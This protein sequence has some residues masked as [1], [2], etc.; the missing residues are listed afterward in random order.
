M[1]VVHDVENPGYGEFEIFEVIIPENATEIPEDAFAIQ[2]IEDLIIPDGVKKI[3]NRA[4]YCCQSLR[5]IVLPLSLESIGKGAF[6]LCDSLKEIIIGP[7]SI[8]GEFGYMNA[9]DDRVDGREY[10]SG[11]EKNLIAAIKYIKTKK[12]LK[13]PTGDFDYHFMP[14]IAAGLWAAESSEEAEDYLG[15]CCEITVEMLLEFNQAY[16]MQALLNSKSLKDSGCIEEAIEY[17]SGTLNSGKYNNEASKVLK[18]YICGNFNYFVPKPEYM[19]V[20]SSYD[21]SFSA[22]E[23]KSVTGEEWNA[24]QKEVCIINKPENGILTPD[25]VLF[26][27]HKNTQ[28]IIY[29]RFII[30]KAV[31]KIT[32]GCFPLASTILLC[33]KDTEIEENGVS[34]K[35]KLIVIGSGK[36]SDYAQKNGNEIVLIPDVKPTPPE[37]IKYYHNDKYVCR[38]S[39]VLNPRTDNK[40]KKETAMEIVLSPE[41]SLNSIKVEFI[42]EGN[43]R[44]P[45][46]MDFRIGNTIAYLMQ[47]DLIKFENAKMLDKQIKADIVTEWPLSDNLSQLFNS[48]IIFNERIVPV[49]K[50]SDMPYDDLFK[51]FFPSV[52]LSV[53]E[54]EVYSIIK[55]MEVPNCSEQILRSLYEPGNKLSTAFSKSKYRLC[56]VKYLEPDKYR[57]VGSPEIDVY[58]KDNTAFYCEDD[59][60]LSEDEA[61]FA[62]T[63]IK[64]YH[65]LYDS[66]FSENMSEDIKKIKRDLSIISPE[67]DKSVLSK[68]FGCTYSDFITEYEAL[69]PS[70]SNTSK[71]NL[72]NFQ[73]NYFAMGIASRGL[74]VYK[75]NK[76]KDFKE[77]EEGHYTAKVEGTKVYDIE[78]YIDKDSM[79]I[80]AS[81][82]CPY[83]EDMKRAWDDSVYRCKHTAAVFY[84]IRNENL[85]NKIFNPKLTFPYNRK[86]KTVSNIQTTIQAKNVSD[87]K[88]SS[89]PKG[90]KVATETV[91]AEPIAKPSDI[92]E[93]SKK[94]SSKSTPPKS[95]VKA[96]SG[97]KPNLL[98]INK[99]MLKKCSKDAV[100]VVVPDGVKA[101]CNDAFKDCKNL[102][103]VLLPDSVTRIGKNAFKG[104]S[105]LE[106]INI[107]DG[108]TEIPNEAFGNTCGLKAITLG[109]GLKNIDFLM[110]CAELRIIEVD[111]GNPLYSSYDGV[112]YDKD[113]ETLLICPRGKSQLTIP[114]SVKYIKTYSDSTG[115]I[116]SYTRLKHIE[117][118]PGN[119]V[120]ASIDGILYDKSIT[121]LLYCPH[122]I[123]SVKVPDRVTVIGRYAFWVSDIQ[124][125]SLGSGITV[126]EKSAFCNCMGLKN[127]IIPDSVTVIGQSAFMW[128]GNLQNITIPESVISIG[129][130][131][132]HECDNLIK[133]IILNPSLALDYCLP[134]NYYDSQQRKIDVIYKIGD[135]YIDGIVIE[136]EELKECNSKKENIVLPN[137]I[138]KISDYAFEKNTHIKSII[139]PDG[140]TNIGFSAFGHCENLREVFLPDTL[141][142]I[143]SYAFSSC[144][145]L[146]EITIPGSVKEIGDNAFFNCTNLFSVT[147]KNGVEIISD[148]AFYLCEKLSKLTLPSSIIRIEEDAFG[149][150]ESLENRNVIITSREAEYSYKLKDIDA[151]IRSIRNKID[152][153]TSSEMKINEIN[154]QISKLNSEKSRLGFFKGKQK[155]ALQDQIDALTEQ[156]G[157]LKKSS[158]VEREKQAQPYA[159]R[160]RKLEDERNS[161][162]D[163]INKEKSN[164]NRV[165]R[166]FIGSREND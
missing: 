81:C 63:Y 105:K 161:I 83:C 52:K 60:P 56:A 44:G 10:F 113:V 96:D 134:N 115:T 128:C 38:G 11:F 111:N 57:F 21:K 103:S 14:Q 9:P 53:A 74:D 79:I 13:D 6:D 64:Q 122:D 2:S 110:D 32:A 106:R 102:I 148:S 101:I 33:N 76:I 107:P 22:I 46:T 61:R 147:I 65:R 114:K 42:A 27:E 29:D 48:R 50:N 51:E 87:T 12:E 86:P 133:V 90:S 68:E 54:A 99:G 127:I 125:V 117:V 37:K 40:A 146:T 82:D 28:A 144:I 26:A 58:I 34:K 150:C 149:S 142:T 153:P 20:R 39:I 124:E 7:V 36:V 95:T 120:F 4:F 152:M 93:T 18:S 70:V 130:D 137:C 71:I 19:I 126:I 35:A 158:A 72:R 100:D 104:C 159:Q 151:Q 154:V 73:S 16:Q 1:A 166:L 43:K 15:C 145:T 75:S 112:L 80:S 45:M 138:K 47:N 25:I 69:F 129:E 55:S 121:K 92:E 165:Q 109:N 84:K 108:V 23:Y 62:Y 143:D 8:K 94:E 123:K 116:L 156:I 67:L 162:I 155:K 135:S 157:Q 17:V 141:T 97:S 49:L 59:M 118:D 119:E 164:I 132:F 31:S 78:V 140:V 163:A 85:D 98:E 91:S 30:P 24:A 3:G 160:L 136:S 89:V 66:Q 139:I 5:R 77:I 131:A 88:V 41:K